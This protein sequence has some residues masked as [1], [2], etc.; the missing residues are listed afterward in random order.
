MVEGWKLE[1]VRAEPELVTPVG[2]RF[3]SQ[4]RL[5]VVECHTHFPPDAY[6]GPKVDRIYRFEDSDGNGSLDKQTLFYEGGVATMGVATW[7]DGWLYVVTRSRIDR[8][9]DAD[10]DGRAEQQESLIRLETTA[11]YPHNGL[12]SIAF[13]PDGWLYFGQGENFGQ[14]YRLI[15][16][17]GLDSLAVAKVETFFVVERMDPIASVLRPDFGIL[18]VHALMRQAGSGRSTTILTL[19]HHVG[20]SMW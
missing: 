10:G 20:S 16:R 5:F 19:D 8:I 18:S 17:M 3:D 2:C 1:L 15:G 9:R 4:G 11:D 14:P 13:G 7:K 6:P 12:S